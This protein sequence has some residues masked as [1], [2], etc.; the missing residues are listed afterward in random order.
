[1]PIWHTL[2]PSTTII[3]RGVSLPCVSQNKKKSDEHCTVIEAGIEGVYGGKSSTTL[4]YLKARS[5]MGCC[6]FTST[7]QLEATQGMERVRANWV[8]NAE[9]KNINLLNEHVLRGASER[10]KPLKL[11]RDERKALLHARPAVKLIIEGGLSFVRVGI[12]GPFS[13][14]W[15]SPTLIAPGNPI[16]LPLCQPPNYKTEN[17]THSQLLMFAFRNLFLASCAFIKYF[18]TASAEICSFCVELNADER[19]CIVAGLRLKSFE[20]ILI[21]G[22]ELKLPQRLRVGSGSWTTSS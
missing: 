3:A 16:R 12:F 6:E 17:S 13:N 21:D 2:Q 19:A 20:V 7:R 11:S 10:A 15:L 4:N 18:M 8:L 22:V 14:F 9:N 1:M 5:K